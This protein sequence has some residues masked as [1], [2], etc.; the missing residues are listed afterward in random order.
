MEWGGYLLS[1]AY[2]GNRARV[3]AVLEERRDDIPQPGQPNGWGLWLIPLSGVEALYVVGERERAAA[4]F[5]LVRE[6]IAT[7]AVVLTT[8][9]CRLAERVA[10]IAAA[11]GEQWEV[12][13]SHFHS[14]LRQA[15]E[16][17]HVLEGAESRRFYAQMLLERDR[18]GDRDEARRLLEEAMTVYRRIGMP[19][20]VD[21][22]RNLLT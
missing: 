20:H 19:R 14:A 9:H 12:A 11:A 4:L 7:T 18:P 6:F 5:P 3:L 22:A 10:G 1:L 21:M 17:P 16:L 13:E 15:E 8:W 2:G